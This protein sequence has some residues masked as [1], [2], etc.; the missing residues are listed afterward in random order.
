MAYIYKFNDSMKADMI[1]ISES[2]EENVVMHTHSFFEF[3]YV[4]SGSA[5]QIINSKKMTVSQGDYFLI[6]LKGAHEYK[7]IEGAGELKVINCLFL[8][9]FL[10]RTLEGRAEFSEICDSI[11]NYSNEYAPE[12]VLFT[13]YR[14]KDGFVGGIMRRMLREYREKKN[15]YKEIL[16]NLLSCLII[17]LLRGGEIVEKDGEKMTRRPHNPT[18]YIKKYVHENYMNEVS[19]SK[20]AEELG[21]SLTHVSLSF[22]KD[23]GM[24]FR[25]YLAFVRMERA[26]EL[27][28]STE[29]TISEISSLVGYE[30]DTFFYKSFKRYYGV[31]PREFNDTQSHRK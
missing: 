2:L 12:S 6:D 13:P 26:R 15:G 4:A 19:L 28:S 20:I 10:D 5:E 1:A 14:D 23:T 27:L 31:T 29:K 8:P 11:L 22:K 21:Y 17:Y 25:D 30:D 18:K 7:K 24:S 9:S 3:V 16:K